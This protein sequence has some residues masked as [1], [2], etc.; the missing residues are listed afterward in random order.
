MTVYLSLGSNLGD[1]S[2]NIR[3]AIQLLKSVGVNVTKTSALYEA[4]PWGITNQPDFLNLVLKGETKSPPEELL[5]ETKTIEK[6]TG[7][8]STKKWGS[9]II[10][11]DIL[12]Y[13]KE[14][15]N[16]SSLTIPHP[17]LHK[18]AFVLVPLKEIAPHLVHPLLKKTPRQ[19]LNNLKDK[20]SVVLYNELK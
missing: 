4:S 16:T 2:K 15:I 13:K 18:R 3:N 9:R 12:F 7:R 14:I 20:S 10:D 19:M 6:T 5:K 1:R 11:I 17:Q 8:K